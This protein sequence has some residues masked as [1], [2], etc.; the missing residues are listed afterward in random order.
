E[1][2]PG[3]KSAAMQLD[4]AQAA[5]LAGIPGNPSAFDPLEHSQAAF[6]R[7]ESVLGLMQT[8]GYITKVNALDAIKEA[9]NPNFFKTAPSLTNR[10]PHFTN[11]VLSDLVQQSH[12]TDHNHL[13]RTAIP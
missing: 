3:G 7:F 11:F 1:E 9:Q 10:A 12:L 8:Q 5:M 6:I 13:H 4:L 2:L